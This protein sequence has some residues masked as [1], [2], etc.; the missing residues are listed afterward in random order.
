MF[1]G[2]FYYVKSVPSS[3]QFFRMSTWTAFER[4][5]GL[6]FTLKSVWYSADTAVKSSRDFVC[7]DSYI[8][9]YSP[10]IYRKE[11]S[12]QGEKN[13]KIVWDI[14]QVGIVN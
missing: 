14:S 10:F 5:G 7:L 6:V 1:A 11:K 13:S 8:Q 2:I 3:L 12:S 9:D 4:F